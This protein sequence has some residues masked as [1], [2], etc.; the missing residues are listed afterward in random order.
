MSPPAPLLTKAATDRGGGWVPPRDP[1][2]W[3]KELEQHVGWKHAVQTAS[4]LTQKE[5]DG[6]SGQASDTKPRVTG[7]DTTLQRKRRNLGGA[8]WHTG[9]S[10][11]SRALLPPCRSGRFVP[12]RNAGLLWVGP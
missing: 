7:R 1:K 2:V 5:K 12:T 4:Y 8:A 10:E 6:D 3:G 9:P 11:G